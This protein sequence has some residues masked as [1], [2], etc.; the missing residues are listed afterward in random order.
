[1][2]TTL[3]ARAPFEPPRT[4]ALVCGPEI[5][6]RYTLLELARRG[7][8]EANMY[9]SL[10]RNMKCGVGT[11]GHCQLG[12][13]FVCRDGPVFSYGRVKWLLGKAEV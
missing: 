5:M 7:V 11:C 6:M 12:P 3:L 10:E 1:M 9:L 13:F 4:V 8:G 2:V